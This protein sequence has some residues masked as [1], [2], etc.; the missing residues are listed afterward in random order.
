M[1]FDDNFR[2]KLIKQLTLNKKQ[3]SKDLVAIATKSFSTYFDIGFYSNLVSGI[4]DINLEYAQKIILR[5]LDDNSN[6]YY[7]GRKLHFKIIRDDDYVPVDMNKLFSINDLKY[8]D[9]Y[10]EKLN[11]LSFNKIIDHNIINDQRKN[12]TPNN[13]I[14]GKNF[15][16]V[17]EDI[18]KKLYPEYIFSKKYS[19]RT[20]RF[21]KEITNGYFLGIEY[22]HRLFEQELKKK[23]HI[24]EFRIVLLNENF[25]RNISDKEYLFNSNNTILFLDKLMNPFFAPPVIEI[26]TIFSKLAFR[27]GYYY[28]IGKFINKES[29][30]FFRKYTY[31]QMQVNKHYI[32][33]YI[34]YLTASIIETINDKSVYKNTEYSDYELNKI[35]ERTIFLKKFIPESLEKLENASKQKLISK[36]NYDN[37]KKMLEMSQNELDKNILI[38][39]KNNISY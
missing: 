27:N 14:D 31:Y 13:I 20:H 22:D 11:N 15:I 9:F 30:L 5:S 37:Q 35:K 29:D 12:T 1:N 10:N 39:Q 25:D 3:Y 26:S 36:S 7:D 4:D 6:P 16:S 19:S 23:I 17:V 18:F 28:E 8:S 21:I 2:R 33:T 38:L 24:P 34:D 32:S